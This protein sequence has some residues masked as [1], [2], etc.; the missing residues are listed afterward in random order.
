[1]GYYYQ[2]TCKYTLFVAQQG[3]FIW[4]KIFERWNLHEQQETIIKSLDVGNGSN[5]DN[6]NAEC[7][8]C[9]G[10]RN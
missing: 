9:K 2:V 10:S 7:H 5:I 8:Y 3:V 1:M 6:H 4:D